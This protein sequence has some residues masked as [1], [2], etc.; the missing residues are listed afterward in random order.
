MQTKLRYDLYYLENQGFWL[1]LR[2]ALATLFHLVRIPGPIIARVFRFPFY[3]SAPRR[4]HCPGESIAVS[5]PR[6][7]RVCELSGKVTRL[8]MFELSPTTFVA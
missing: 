5:S 2:I 8:G 7:G 6:S 3:A 4:G 1:D